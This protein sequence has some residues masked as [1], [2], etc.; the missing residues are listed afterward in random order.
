MVERKRKP[1]VRPELAR[2]WLQRNE[3]DGESPPQIAQADGYD[4]R[5]IRKQ[6]EIMRQEREIRQ[7]KQTVLRQ[8]L[9]KHYVDI[10]SF[11]EQLK[12]QIGSRTPSMLSPTIR[13]EPMWRAL[14]QHLP[15]SPLWKNIDKLE[16]LVDPFRLSLDRIKERVR[17][18]AVSRTSLEFVSSAGKTGLGEGLTDSIVFHLLASARA[19]KRLISTG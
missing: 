19:D 15:R 11:A 6:L 9:E 14:Q 1:K 13:E 2:K 3:E 7:A 4:V 10:C 18:E 5:T 17:N 16:R 8:A 12:A